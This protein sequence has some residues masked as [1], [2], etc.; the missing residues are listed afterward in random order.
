MTWNVD[1]D[2]LII[3][4]LYIAEE[5]NFRTW[6]LTAGKIYTYETS[7]I[8]LNFSEISTIRAIKENDG[9]YTAKT[10]I[11]DVEA[12]ASSYYIDYESKKLYVHTSTGEPPAT[13]SDVSGDY[14]FCILMEFWIGLSSGLR[15]DMGGAFPVQGNSSAVFYRPVIIGPPEL[16][17]A[18]GEYYSGA[19]KSD[20]GELECIPSLWLVSALQKWIFQGR[21]IVI[22]TA[23]P[24]DSYGSFLVISRG[25][26]KN[27]SKTERGVRLEIEDRRN[28]ELGDIPP[29]TFSLSTYP[30]MDSRYD[31][32]PIPIPFG[33]VENIIP[34]LIDSSTWRY[35]ASP[36]AIDSFLWIKKDGILLTPGTDYTA[37]PNSGEFTLAVDPG[38][39]LI[40]CG[41]KGIKI[42]YFGASAAF[43]ENIANVL[44]F[45]LTT[46]CGIPQS[47]LDQSS[48]NVL[49]S[50]RTQK[51]SWW[52]APTQ[53]QPATEVIRRLMATFLFHL[54]TRPDGKYYVRYFEPGE[55]G[56]TEFRTEDIISLEDFREDYDSV[57][58][59]VVILYDFNPQT[60]EW[61]RIEISSPKTEYRYKKKN[62]LVIE[63]VLRDSAEAEAL[64]DKYLLMYRSPVRRL[65]ISLQPLAYDLVPADK[66]KITKLL[67]PE[68]TPLYL[69]QN[70]V[71]IILESRID[72]SKPYV[73]IR[74][75][76]LSQAA[77]AVHSDVAHEDSHGDSHSD[78]PHSD[79]AHGD[80]TYNDH[81]DTPHSDSHSDSYSDLAHEDTAHEDSH[82]D[83]SHSDYTHNDHEDHYDDPIHDDWGDYIHDDIAHTDSHSDSHTD[84]PH[85]DS[86]EDSHSD[87]AHEDESHSDH[88]DVPHSDTAHSDSHSDSHS[89]IPHTDSWY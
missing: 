15:E 78:I 42:S 11:N 63:S 44:Y 36:Y 46:L 69:L 77:G 22:K 62:S 21:E 71:Y 29:Q 47:S 32:Q 72:F 26:V 89:D 50:A 84:S 17:L 43:S 52:F 54:V 33:Q 58:S 40:T 28:V 31:G 2:R 5:I 7:I 88:S 66:I 35:K 53:K 4:E 56:A 34:I 65:N 12:T 87:T 24:G 30:N 81:D 48:F 14:K 60:G 75:I 61:K 13:I 23:R 16:T 74:A 83:S 68:G 25:Y 57:Y 37:Y 20:I 45:I 3:A 1:I 70:A 67:Y 27:V 86:H 59:S 6:A 85:Q 8:D 55:T 41:V 76:D 80:G 64:A 51:L 18:V 49:Q 19:M 10:S 73:E 38:N 9:A 79:T 39:S 82:G